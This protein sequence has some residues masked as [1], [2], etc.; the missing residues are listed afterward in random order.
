MASCDE[1]LSGLITLVD[2]EDN[3][4]QVVGAANRPD[5]RFVYYLV[6]QFDNTTSSTGFGDDTL[7]GDGVQYFSDRTPAGNPAQPFDANAPD[8]VGLALT[9]PNGPLV[10]TLRSWGNVQSTYATIECRNG[11]LLAANADDGTILVLSFSPF[12]R[13]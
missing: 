9:S 2:I 4:I 13:Q 5:N 6:G 3:I 1:L 11:L 7:T 8:V 10:L 12:P